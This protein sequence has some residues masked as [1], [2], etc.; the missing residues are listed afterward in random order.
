MNIC[1]IFL[2]YFFSDQAESLYVSLVRYSVTLGFELLPL[3][4]PGRAGPLHQLPRQTL[5]PARSPP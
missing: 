5:V 2:Y 3:L 4:S 1:L